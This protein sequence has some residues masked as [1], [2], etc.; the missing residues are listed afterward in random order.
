MTPFARLQQRFRLAEGG[1]MLCAVLLLVALHVSALT[2]T[3]QDAKPTEY[4]VKA[5]YLADLGR[6]VEQWSSP[7]KPASDDPFAI[8]ILGQDPFGANLDRAVTGEKIGGTTVVAKRIARAQEAM[9][10]KVLFISSSE[11]NQWSAILATLGSSP[12]LTVADFPDFVKRGGMIQFV[13][14]ANHVRFEINLGSAQR[15]GLRLSSELLKVA[16]LVRRTP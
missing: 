16:R 2:M 9:G 15:A 8:C 3:A 5:A 6:F 1:R 11:E 12:V 7:S 10:C 13:L 4:Q 14:D